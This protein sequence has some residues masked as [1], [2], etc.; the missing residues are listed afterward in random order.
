[1]EERPVL[2]LGA[3]LAGLSGAYHLEGHRQAV[4]LEREDR[5]GG[6]TRSFH[7]QGF[8]FD[9]TGH[10]LHLRRPE[11]KKLVARLLP[12]GMAPIERNSF[13]Y[14]HGRYTDYPFQA[15]LHGLPPGVIRDCLVG[16]AETLAHKMPSRREA[17]AS[18]SFRDWVLGT[19]GRGIAEHFMFPYNRKLWC[20]DLNDVTAEWVSWSVPQPVF[21]EVVGGA[22][23]LKNRGMGYNPVFQYPVSGGIEVLPEALAA[24]LRRTRVHLKTEVCSVDSGTR[25]VRTVDGRVWPYSTL[26]S[27]LPLPRLLKLLVQPPDWIAAVARSLRATSVVNI[28]LGVARSDLTR[29]HWIYFPEEEFVFYRVGSPTAFCQ[30]SAP[31]GCSSLYVEV[32]RL[33]LQPGELPGLVDRVKKDLLRCGLLRADDSIAAQ[34][35]TVI[36][37]AYVIFDRHRQACLPRVLD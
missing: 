3:G 34:Q 7:V 22:L 1:M 37:P 32:A 30:A 29:R 2:I 14:S 16:L 25:R 24:A 5:V 11:V 18:G 9:L 4:I 20:T 23:G 31:P 15:N 21:E 12:D 35:V 33:G 27:T 17:L 36:H 19:F 6:L 8:T 13:I 26:I 28:N 10:L